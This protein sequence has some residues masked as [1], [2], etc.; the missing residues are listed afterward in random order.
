MTSPGRKA[1][2]T[3][4]DGTSTLTSYPAT[5]AGYAAHHEVT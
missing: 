1:S 5:C 2:V 3:A 4:P